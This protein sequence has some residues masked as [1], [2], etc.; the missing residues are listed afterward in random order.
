M[1]FSRIPAN[2]PIEFMAQDGLP[3]EVFV[4]Q[5]TGNVSEPM[6]LSDYTGTFTVYTKAGAEIY[7][8]EDVTLGADG[9]IS[10]SISRDEV[11]SWTQ[12]PDRYAVQ[13]FP[14]LGL[15]L[16]IVRGTFKPLAI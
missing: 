9:K 7:S 8:S 12:C 4:E 14:P 6:D 3:F 1:S 11:A 15:P 5:Q 13:I 10:H 16:T 2:E